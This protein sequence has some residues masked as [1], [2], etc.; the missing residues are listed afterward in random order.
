MATAVLELTPGQIIAKHQAQAPVDV[1]AIADELGINVWETKTFPSSVSGKIFKDPVNGG[2]SGFSILV[3]A[4]HSLFRKR[5]TIAHEIAHFI[6][7]RKRLESG[8]LID[9]AMYRSGVS[10]KEETEANRY[11]A[12]ILMPYSLIRSLMAA[13]IRTPEQLATRLQV[14]LPAMKIRL[15]LPLE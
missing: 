5:F 1:V 3:N 15:G 9:D 10:A 6:L 7:H 13:G 14:S 11:A 2:R 8:E 4:G 12:E